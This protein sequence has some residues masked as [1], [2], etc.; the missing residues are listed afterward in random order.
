ATGAPPASPAFGRPAPFLGSGR[1]KH[2]V[3]HRL[4]TPPLRPSARSRGGITA[5][6]G[7]PQS[8]L[9]IS[10]LRPPRATGEAQM[11]TPVGRSADRQSLTALSVL[12]A[13]A[14]SQSDHRPHRPS[15]IRLPT[16]PIPPG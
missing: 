11:T 2:R 4:H 9:G 6:P 5:V 14:E 8:H 1:A 13:G 3:A 12:A 15:T 10:R 16:P 7:L